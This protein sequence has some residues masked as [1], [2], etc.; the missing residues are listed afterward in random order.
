MRLSKKHLKFPSPFRTLN[1][2]VII[3]DFTEFISKNRT[4]VR[5]FVCYQEADIIYTM[6]IK[7]ISEFK[8]AHNLN[9]RSV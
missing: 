4:I 6:K 9:Y 3:K 7:I 5:F 2:L 1:L 8:Q